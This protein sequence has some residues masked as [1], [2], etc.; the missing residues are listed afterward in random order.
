MLQK[1]IMSSE[2]RRT[3]GRSRRGTG[4]G[5]TLDTSFPWGI[6][7][8]ATALAVALVSVLAYAVLNTGSAAPD[9][10]R[11]AEGAVPGLEV[12][13]T[14]PGQAHEPGALDY[15]RSPSWGG[16]HN[17]AWSTCTGQ[18]YD[19]PVPE[20]HATHSLEHGA[21][22]I[23]YQPD[24]PTEQVQ[25]LEQLVEGADYRLLSPFPGQDDP[26]SIQAWGRQ[27]VV[28][29]ASDDRLQTFAEE[30]T[31]GPQTPERGAT[32]AS[33]TRATGEDPAA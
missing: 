21:V 12:A 6:L 27:L 9:Q 24:L 26:I 3:L 1:R 25:A 17:P 15:D 29:D 32:C 7:V 16:P 2:H 20:E 18:V 13:Q 10:L 33:G 4:T 14:P 23:T 30:F 8:G 19:E 31:N 5:T 28:D 11:S 22:W